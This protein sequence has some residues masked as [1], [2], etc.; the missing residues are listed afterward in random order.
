MTPHRTSNG[1]G[2]FMLDR[3]FA[4]VGRIHRASGTTDART[5]R[6]MNAM[7]TRLF[8]L[9]RLD[10]LRAIRT[11]DLHPL[12][13]Y[14][15]YRTGELKELPDLQTVRSLAGDWQQ[16]QEAT[17]RK[18]TRRGRGYAWSKLEDVL[19]SR[20][21]LA[22]L[23]EALRALRQ[24]LHEHPP[25]FNRT[26]AAVLAFVRDTVG[27]SHQLYASCSDVVP[28]RERREKRA[29]PPIAKAIR[30]RE[31]LPA[32]A[33]AIWWSMY[34]TGMGPDEFDSGWEIVGDQVRIPGTKREA[35]DRLIPVFGMLERR[36]MGWKQYRA[37]LATLP[38][39][40]RVQRYDA[41]RGFLHLLEEARV[42][43]IRRK[44]YA[45]HALGDVTGGY[46]RAELEAFVAQ[47]R[48]AVQR[49]LAEVEQAV[50]AERRTELKR[51]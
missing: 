31:A 44:M 30:V 6:G 9:G 29:A 41:R 10:T 49:K 3:R 14:N 7:L 21:T 20:A 5:L 8:E 28:L 11:G 32:P 13:A 26:R 42:T 40:L 19:S 22:E 12:V 24:E 37:A 25:A 43:R 17:P 34:L 1:R 16:W 23:P 48:Q 38:A 36:A 50:A 45:G 15:L 2:T 35:R 27:R 33:A 51:A 39:V 47:D 4:G 46:E 18:Q